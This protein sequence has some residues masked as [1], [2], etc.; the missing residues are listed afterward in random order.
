MHPTKTLV[1]GIPFLFTALAACS[2]VAEDTARP[3]TAV[4][5][6]GPIAT[7]EEPSTAA[8]EPGPTAA[9]EEMVIAAPSIQI[10]EISLTWEVQEVGEGIK[11]A[12]AM[13][14]EGVAHVTFLTEAD[15]G[16]LFYAQNRN[17]DFEV[18][19]VVGGYF[20]GP[21][22]LALNP[23]GEPLIAYHDHQGLQF[24]PALG[25]EVIAQLTESGWELTTVADDGHDG[26]DNSI[27]VDE[28]GVWHTAAI[29]PSQFGS[30]SGVEYATLV[31]GAVVVVEVGSGPIKYEF[32]TSIQLDPSGSP[33]VVYYNDRD[34]QLEFASLG[35]DGWSVEV[36]DNQGDV[37]RYASLIFDTDGT[38][39]IAYYVA[40]SRESGTVRH[41]WQDTSGWQ[42]EAV[43]T[44]QNIRMGSPGA[45]KITSLAFDGEG[46]LHL[47]Y[48]D[49][50]QLIYAQKTDEGW[51]GQEVVEPGSVVLGQLV[52]LAIDADGSPH[53]IWYEAA[54]I[55]RYAAGSG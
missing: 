49:R 13:D 28:A 47:A 37:G 40:E 1:I 27:V 29:D 10:G 45:R 18:E 51:I 14:A 34:Q 35:A 20:Y 5:Q 41:A 38:P 26:W 43:G 32:A 48:T 4:A 31:D 17:G 12:F 2:N 23:S 7:E 3:S 24:D 21:I 8:T 15:R 16:A 42:I 9:P 53:L 39:H 11:P 46:T 50:D 44:L 22:D 30:G 54:D 36:V 19:T 25:D 6:P 55:V 52:E 33:A